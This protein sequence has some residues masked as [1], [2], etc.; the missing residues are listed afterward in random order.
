LPSRT[1]LFVAF[2]RWD[3]P[4][5]V[6]TGLDLLSVRK[7]SLSLS[8]VCPPDERLLAS[9]N[10][11]LKQTPNIHSLQFSG[12][13]ADRANPPLVGNVCR[14]IVRYVDPLKLRHLQ[15]PVSSIDDVQ[16]LVGPFKDLLTIK[17]DL[18]G[19]SVTSGQIVEHLKTLT[20]EYSIAMYMHGSSLSITMSRE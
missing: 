14:A 13:L 18:R 16:M 4:K 11:L 17:F 20:N 8:Y 9:L 5:S 15:V 19:R 12:A 10:S 6:A 3:S 2:S 7:L 1:E